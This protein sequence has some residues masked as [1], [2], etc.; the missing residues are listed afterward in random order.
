MD[1]QEVLNWTDEQVFTK[2]GKHLDWLQKSILQGIW[3]H[4]DYYEIAANNEKSYD[5]VKK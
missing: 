2:T 3:Q 5:H 1:I 4:Q